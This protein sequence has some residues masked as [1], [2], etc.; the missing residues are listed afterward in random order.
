[1]SHIE[2]QAMSLE[3]LFGMHRLRRRR[4]TWLAMSLR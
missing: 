2:W 4:R 1:V 3:S